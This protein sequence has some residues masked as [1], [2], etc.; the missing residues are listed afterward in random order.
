MS[1]LRKLR[2]ARQRRYLRLIDPVK[3][4]YEFCPVWANYLTPPSPVQVDTSVGTLTIQTGLVRSFAR[5]YDVSTYSF[6]FSAE[7]RVAFYPPPIFVAHYNEFSQI[8]AR[9]QDAFMA[10][11]PDARIGQSEWG[12]AIY[13]AFFFAP[14]VDSEDFETQLDR[15][16][17]V[18]A[19]LWELWPQMVT[20]T[21][22]IPKFS[23]R[24]EWENGG[25]LV[26]GE[27]IAIRLTIN[28]KDYELNAV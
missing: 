23:R 21:E 4:T 25:K 15:I 11:V 3:L 1:L 18:R 8:A 22:I 6:P 7:E 13:E 9:Q 19:S 28:L 26:S 14:A 24:A 27:W 2:D 10:V 12:E 20:F 16:A 5:E 17:G